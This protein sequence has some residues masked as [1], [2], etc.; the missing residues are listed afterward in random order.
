GGGGR[1]GVGSEAVPDLPA[2][3]E[4][5]PGYETGLLT[6]LGG[7]R[8]TPGDIIEELNKETNNFLADPRLKARLADLGNTALLG[9]SADFG[10][11][12]ADDTEKWA[13]VIRAAKIK[14]E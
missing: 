14:A 5:L 9:S 10:R 6:G 1:G 12:L 8:N 3:P 2:V 13:K 4:F 7:P 11:L